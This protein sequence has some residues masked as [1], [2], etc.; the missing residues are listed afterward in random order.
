MSV[1]INNLFVYQSSPFDEQKTY[2]TTIRVT[3]DG[4]SVFVTCN[5]NLEYAAAYQWAKSNAM[6]DFSQALSS[7]KERDAFLKNNPGKLQLLFEDEGYTLVPQPLFVETESTSYLSHFIE[8]DKL[9][10]GT[11][12][13]S[14]ID[15][16]MVL[17]LINNALTDAAKSVFPDA[18]VKAYTQALLALANTIRPKTQA[19]SI[20]LS[21]N[22]SYFDLVIKK[23]GQLHFFNR[24][25]FS[26]KEDFVYFLIMALQNLEIKNTEVEITLLGEINP[27]SSITEMLN[28]YFS[29]VGFV[30]SDQEFSWDY[31]RYC[32]EQNY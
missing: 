5:R 12:V 30:K 15:K 7:I 19:Y 17:S 9:N 1:D 14:D 24:F 28:R 6:T 13:C 29:E 10:N 25:A 4:L 27:Q 20:I 26:T 8:Q 2:S 21:M 16:V 22:S 32:V 3:S 31:H 11:V 23:R 18:E